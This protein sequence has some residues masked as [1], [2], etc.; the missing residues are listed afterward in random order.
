MQQV[1]TTR[2]LCLW[3]VRERWRGPCPTQF[4][5]IL[6]EIGSLFEITILTIRAAARESRQ[7]AVLDELACIQSHHVYSA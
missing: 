3:H 2:D 5:R 6:E 1:A 4:L 7:L